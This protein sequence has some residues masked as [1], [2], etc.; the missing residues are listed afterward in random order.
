MGAGTEMRVLRNQEGDWR[1]VSGGK[2]GAGVSM[3]RRIGPGEVQDA[4]D[5]GD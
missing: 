1:A 3:R 5:S 2:Q 4:M